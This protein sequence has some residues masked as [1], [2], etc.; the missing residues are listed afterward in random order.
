MITIISHQLTLLQ[1]HD[2]LDKQSEHSV[3]DN[4]ANTPPDLPLVSPQDFAP[5]RE[6]Q[7]EWHDLPT[8]Q[9]GRNR[10]IRKY[11]DNTYGEDHAPSDIV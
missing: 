8:R 10:T 7:Q 6:D 11:P 5:R 1:D 2:D 4:A 9:S 3:H